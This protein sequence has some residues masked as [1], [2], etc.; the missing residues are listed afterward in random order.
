MVDLGARE[1]EEAAEVARADER[2]AALDEPGDDRHDGDQ[3]DDGNGV[4]HLL[5]RRVVDRREQEED[6]RDEGEDERE[7]VADGPE[8]R[9]ERPGRRGE[10]LG[11]EE[12]TP[13]NEEEGCRESRVSFRPLE[14]SEEGGGVR[15]QGD[16]EEEDD[17]ERGG[18]T[19]RSAPSTRG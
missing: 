6:G 13:A 5:G 2:L 9:A 7:D 11:A 10:R 17:E 8:D 19:H 12:V 15:A 4:V 1:L 18:R 16:G 3:A 14:R